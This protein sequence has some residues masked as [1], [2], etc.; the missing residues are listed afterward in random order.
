MREYITILMVDKTK[1]NICEKHNSPDFN[2]RSIFFKCP[3]ILRSCLIIVKEEF[4]KR[5]RVEYDVSKMLTV[6]I[7]KYMI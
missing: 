2:K 1:T 3:V 6:Y 5:Q 4:H 7:S